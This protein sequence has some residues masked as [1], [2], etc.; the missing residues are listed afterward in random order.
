MG[1][2]GIVLWAARDGADGCLADLSGET[3]LFRENIVHSNFTTT[4]VYVGDWR[5]TVS[6]RTNPKTGRQ[7]VVAEPEIIEFEIEFFQHTD[8]KD[9]YKIQSIGAAANIGQEDYEILLHIRK[10]YD[11]R[12]LEV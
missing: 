5:P 2:L 9:S 11:Q 3:Y 12:K 10:N 8:G 6:I 1:Y 4:S 7:F